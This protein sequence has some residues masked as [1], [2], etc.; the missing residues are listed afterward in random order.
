MLRAVIT[1]LPDWHRVV[2]EM[3]YLGK[4]PLAE[5]AQSQGISLGT[6]KSQLHYS[7][8]TLSRALQAREIT[9]QIALGLLD[10]AAQGGVS[11]QLFRRFFHRG[12]GVVDRAVGEF[13]IDGITLT[14][15][16]AQTIQSRIF[17]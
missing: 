17:I 14:P 13:T 1:E 10:E 3:R 8:Q 9:Q 4:R 15:V 11:Q 2:L 5:S 6:L 7:L 12:A 16:H